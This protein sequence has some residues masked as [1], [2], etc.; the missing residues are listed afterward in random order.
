M[1]IVAMNELLF[2]FN[3]TEYHS[4][5]DKKQYSGAGYVLL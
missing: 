4:I 3:M 1:M 5:L 2:R